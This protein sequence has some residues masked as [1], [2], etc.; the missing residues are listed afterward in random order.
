M[1]TSVGDLQISFDCSKC[2]RSI[3]HSSLRNSHILWVKV[4]NLVNQWHLIWDVVVVEKVRPALTLLKVPNLSLKEK[5]SYFYKNQIKTQIHV[6]VSSQHIDQMFRT[7]SVF[8]KN[9]SFILIKKLCMPDL[10]HHACGP[11][12]LV[13]KRLKL[14][15]WICPVFPGTMICVVVLKQSCKIMFRH[16]YEKYP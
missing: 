7:Q 15:L 4:H 5:A 2:V 10:H 6:S 9:V 1:R 8:P 16:L 3:K 14:R 13:C 11:W 12:S